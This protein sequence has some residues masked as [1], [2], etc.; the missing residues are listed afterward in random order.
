MYGCVYV[1]QWDFSNLLLLSFMQTCSGHATPAGKKQNQRFSRRV[2]NVRRAGGGKYSLSGAVEWKQNE[3]EKQSK[4]KTQRDGRNPD[5]NWTSKLA[6][7]V[8]MNIYN[9]G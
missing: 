1:T 7:V 6:G 5:A 3:K 4:R 2:T 8:R 9:E